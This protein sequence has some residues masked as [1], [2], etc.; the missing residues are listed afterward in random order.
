MFT[1]NFVDDLGAD[2]T[3]TDDSD[4]A[5]A[6]LNGFQRPAEVLVPEGTYAFTAATHA[7]DNAPRLTIRSREGENPIFVAPNGYTGEWLSFTTAGE[8]AGVDI[9]RTASGAGPRIHFETPDQLR[10]SDMT[11]VGED[12]AAADGEATITTA[13]TEANARVVLDALGA[14]GGSVYDDANPDSGRDGVR[15][16]SAN[17]GTVRLTDCLLDGYAGWG[18]DAYDSG[19]PLEL[20][21]G[22]LTNNRKGQIRGWHPDLVVRDAT[23]K[24][25][26]KSM[27]GPWPEEYAGGIE[28]AWANEIAEGQATLDGLTISLNAALN[29]DAAGIQARLPSG[30]VGI[31]NCT[32]A[33]HN[34]WTAAIRAEATGTNV[35]SDGPITIKNTKCRGEATAGQA[36]RCYG[37]PVTVANTCIETPGKRTALD[38][39]EDATLQSVSRPHRCW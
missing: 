17:D 18:V 34:D 13:A 10:V 38:V 32:I 1:A 6:A 9:D 8:I 30:A 5:L 12:D 19:G 27:N 20:I 36:V 23:L 14:T 29:G 35:R 39:P 37:R 15:L 31:S 4:S 33:V 24:I 3:G 7:V 25:D 26:T 11:I 28:L 22:T 21:G 16:T 2:P